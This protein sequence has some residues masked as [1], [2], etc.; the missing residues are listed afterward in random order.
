M[1]VFNQ[2]YLWFTSIDPLSD[3]MDYTREFPLTELHTHLGNH[4]KTDG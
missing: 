3:S 2:T 1:M 4:E